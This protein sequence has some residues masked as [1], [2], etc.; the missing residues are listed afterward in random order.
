M[1][2][3]PIFDI[4]FALFFPNSLVL[5]LESLREKTLASLDGCQSGSGDQAP[6]SG[7]LVDW[8]SVGLLYL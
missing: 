3:I 4:I 5:V 1:G 6:G 2:S 8:L 7:K